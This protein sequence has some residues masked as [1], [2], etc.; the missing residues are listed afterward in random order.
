MYLHDED[1]IKGTNLVFMIFSKRKRGTPTYRKTLWEALRTHTTHMGDF[2][3]PGIK[4][5]WG[6]KPRDSTVPFSLITN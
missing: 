6:F 4:N 3:I 5:P 1:R 2:A